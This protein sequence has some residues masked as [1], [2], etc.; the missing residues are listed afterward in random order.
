M[1]YYLRLTQVFDFC[2]GQGF[3]LGMKESCKNVLKRNSFLTIRFYVF[4]CKTVVTPL[5][6][7]KFFGVEFSVDNPCYFRS[8]AQPLFTKIE[9]AQ[10]E[11]GGFC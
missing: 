4:S 11:Y 3:D 1:N 6:Y 5:R 9:I 10:H 7:S 8:M 2:Q